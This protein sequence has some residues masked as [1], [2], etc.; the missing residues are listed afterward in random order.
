MFLIV[1]KL[2][3]CLCIVLFFVIALIYLYCVFSSSIKNNGFLVYSKKYKRS[4]RF[5]YRNG[6]FRP[7]YIL[8]GEKMEEWLNEIK[9]LKFFIT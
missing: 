9:K 6:E 1:I 3:F 5:I 7:E 8:N 4:Q 2:L